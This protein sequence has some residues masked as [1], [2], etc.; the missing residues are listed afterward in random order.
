MD[1]LE[2]AGQNLD[3]LYEDQIVERSRVG[4]HHSH[5]GSKTQAPQ[6]RAF[7]LEIFQ[8]VI[9]PYF[10]GLQ[11]TVE[12]VASSQAQQLPQLHICQPPGLVLFERK[13]FECPA[14]KIASGSGEP[15]RDII[16]DVDGKFHI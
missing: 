9:Q 6:G 11:K 14:G 4:D 5:L 12:F 8:G 10:M 15:L 16:R 7:T 13:S 1:F 2:D 3:S